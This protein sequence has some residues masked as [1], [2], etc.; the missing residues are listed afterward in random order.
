MRNPTLIL[1]AAATCSRIQSTFAASRQL[2]SHDQTYEDGDP[3]SVITISPEGTFVQ[4][5]TV[6]SSHPD[7]PSRPVIQ[8]PSTENVV[9]HSDPF[10][11]GMGRRDDSLAY[12][13]YAPAGEPYD[14]V[15]GAEDDSSSAES[16]IDDEDGSE[17]E[18]GRHDHRL[19]P[20]YVPLIHSHPASPST[21][22][23]DPDTPNSNSNNKRATMSVSKTRMPG[24]SPF[25]PGPVMLNCTIFNITSG[26]N[27]TLILTY[28]IAL[29]MTINGTRFNSTSGLNLPGG[30]G[31]VVPPNCTLVENGAESE[32]NRGSG[33]GG[34]LSPFLGGLPGGQGGVI[35]HGSS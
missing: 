7:P 22:S 24:P 28:P 10:V 34:R 13:D 1:L 31:G 35:P 3:A 23:P 20:F 2:V 8:K 32:G 12:T 33:N 21:S 26:L 15:D 4:S 29:N 25:A 5:I 18:H 6:D 17:E 14:G 9:T 11:S 30:Q 27:S 19:F 16:T